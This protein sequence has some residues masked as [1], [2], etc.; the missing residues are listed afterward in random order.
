MWEKQEK[1]HEEQQKKH[2]VKNCSVNSK[3]KIGKA[4]ACL[5][6]IF[7]NCSGNNFWE[8]FLRIV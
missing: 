3:K 7:E 8:Q 1:K 2:E 5:I 4:K 6:V